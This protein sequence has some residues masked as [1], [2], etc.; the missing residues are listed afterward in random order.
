M[1]R[2]SASQ[3]LS[4]R[5]TALGAFMGGVF[6]HGGG[7]IGAFTS[8][9]T[10][11]DSAITRF[12][13]ND[14]DIF[15][16]KG[17][18]INIGD[19]GVPEIRH[20]R[21]YGGNE[22]TGFGVQ[23]A[24]IYVAGKKAQGTITDNEIYGNKDGIVLREGACPHI[25]RNHIHDQRRRGV[26][27]CA[28]GQGM[29]LDNVIANSGHYNIEVRGEKPKIMTPE[30]AEKE[31]EK[32]KKLYAS[33]GLLVALPKDGVTIAGLIT[34]ESGKTSIS[35]R[36]NNLKGGETGSVHMCDWSIGFMKENTITECNG[37]AIIG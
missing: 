7:G 27:V 31:L 1:S 26:M 25:E 37:S 22:Y 28:R 11:R 4:L 3:R 24:A 14:N 13:L 32:K 17:V 12:T 30:K 8:D 18:G 29:L 20:N 33:M 35:M 23:N 21:I 34:D 10:N 9:F 6:C 16:N 5:R 2:S 36:R 15:G 19:D